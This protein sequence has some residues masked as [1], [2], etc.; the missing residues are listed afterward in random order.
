MKKLLVT[1]F[2]LGSISAFASEEKYCFSN[3]SNSAIIFAPHS[4]QMNPDNNAAGALNSFKAII[5]ALEYRA[6]KNT[7]VFESNSIRGPLASM[8]WEQF[9]NEGYVPRFVLFDAQGCLERDISGFPSEERLGV[10]F[11]D[12]IGSVGG[13][14]GKRPLLQT[15][16]DVN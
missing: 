3:R 7:T 2:A 1:L 16:L 14:P 4:S 8:Y 15:T 12:V 13:L 11:L 6:K 10:T 9:N 5:W